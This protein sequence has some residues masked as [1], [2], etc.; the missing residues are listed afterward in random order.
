MKL[1]SRK[2][3]LHSLHSRM[4]PFPQ[5]NKKQQS[6]FYLW[7]TEALIRDA[8][9]RPPSSGVLMEVH[10]LLLLFWW[11]SIS[12]FCCFDGDGSP[13]SLFVMEM[14]LHLLFFWW[15]SI[16]V[17][18]RP[19]CMLS[20]DAPHTTHS[21][22]AK[23]THVCYQ[24]IHYTGRSTIPVDQLYRTIFQDPDATRPRT[25]SAQLKQHR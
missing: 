20:L 22:R 2:H 15:R 10:L 6:L 21:S 19:P 23:N 9:C 13:S 3:S 7:N 8:G 17:S 1:C 25:P 4:G 24:T 18:A 11:R 14:D 5:K 12:F 16:S